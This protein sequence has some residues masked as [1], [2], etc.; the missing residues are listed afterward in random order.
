M[1]RPLSA[2]NNRSITAKSAELKSFIS[3]A[4][5]QSSCIPAFDA[6]H[7]AASETG[8][9]SKLLT[10]PEGTWA[11]SV[12]VFRWLGGLWLVENSL[13]D[14]VGWKAGKAEY[15]SWNGFNCWGV[16]VCEEFVGRT[17]ELRSKCIT[18]AGDSLC[19]LCGDRRLCQRSSFVNGAVK[20]IAIWEKNL[21]LN[22]L[23][24]RPYCYTIYQCD[25]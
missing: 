1:S 7:K 6:S 4:I 5:S 12:S 13:D 16:A 9:G 17:I 11:F 21:L 10:N 25:Y 3:S 19:R 8:A 22:H 2:Y 20:T 23:L 15:C 24:V 18:G 14:I